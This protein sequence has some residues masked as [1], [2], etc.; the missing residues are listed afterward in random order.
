MPL[1]IRALTIGAVIDHELAHGLTTEAESSTRQA[2]VL[3]M[4]INPDLTMGEKLADLGGLTIALTLI[5]HRFMVRSEISAS[6][7]NILRALRTTINS[8]WARYCAKFCRHAFH[9][10]YHDLFRLKDGHGQPHFE[11]PVAK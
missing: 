9:V 5:T 3:G 4:H 11:L 7:E 1:P 2:P 10:T 8:V 6:W